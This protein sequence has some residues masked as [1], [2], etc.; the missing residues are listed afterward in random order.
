MTDT[1][2]LHMMLFIFLLALF[3]AALGVP[4]AL[5]SMRILDRFPSG[6]TGGLVLVGNLACATVISG[7]VTYTM[8]HWT[9]LNAVM[10]S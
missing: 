6:L 4:M 2:F 10:S 8:M 3:L 5:L 1:Q 9:W 7:V